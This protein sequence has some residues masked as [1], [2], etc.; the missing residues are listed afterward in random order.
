MRTIDN[1]KTWLA[2]KQEMKKELTALYAKL[3]Q[4]EGSAAEISDLKRML[5]MAEKKVRDHEVEI[6][7][8]KKRLAEVNL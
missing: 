8:L 3:K 5:S 7:D 1:Q 2:E 6:A 4:Y